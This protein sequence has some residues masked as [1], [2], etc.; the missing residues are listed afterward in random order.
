MPEWN[1]SIQEAMLQRVADALGPGLLQDMA[2]VGG[3]TTGLLIT[4]PV[5]REA[6]RF[7][8]DVD[9]IVHVMGQATG[10]ACS[11]NLRARASVPHP[12]MM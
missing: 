10:T 12:K 11:R 6:V 9:L 4:D 1:W 5:S 2:F 7:T 3:C 8:D